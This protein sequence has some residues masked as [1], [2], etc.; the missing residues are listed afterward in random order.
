VYLL[1]TIIVIILIITSL[2]IKQRENEQTL[3][4]QSRKIAAQSLE[5]K[6]NNQALSLILALEAYKHAPTF[7]AQRAIMQSV[8]IVDSRT[9]VIIRNQGFSMAFSPDGQALAIGGLDGKIYLFDPHTLKFIGL[10]INSSQNIIK[11]IAYSSDGKLLATLD[12]DGKIFIWDTIVAKALETPDEEPS[13]KIIGFS[14]VPSYNWLILA[15][16]IEDNGNSE[17]IMWD[18]L[19]SNYIGE[20]F[21]FNCT[22][23][24][25]IAT[26]INENRQIMTAY[27]GQLIYFDEGLLEFLGDPEKLSVPSGIE[28]TPKGDHIIYGRNNE[29]AFRTG[30]V[31]LG[32]VSLSN[33]KLNDTTEIFGTWA[34]RIN[35]LA[36]SKDGTT[37]VIGGGGND[38][39]QF[40]SVLK[41]FHSDSSVDYSLGGFSSEVLNVSI[42]PDNI[43]VAAGDLDGNIIL[44]DLTQ[45]SWKNIILEWESMDD[46]DYDMVTF[47]SDSNYVIATRFDRIYTWDLSTGLK[48]SNISPSQMFDDNLENPREVTSPD[49]A[50]KATAGESTL[51]IDNS[52][53]QEL[54]SLSRAGYVKF[55]PNGKYLI[56]YG[57]PS[58]AYIPHSPSVWN[59]NIDDWVKKICEIVVG[60]VSP[61]EW[62]NYIGNETYQLTC[63]IN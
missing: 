34:R 41:N 30:E 11:E 18:I 25:K 44:W 22:R 19:K 20:S 51:L 31:W 42:S 10:P 29:S 54:I 8:Q 37:L 46:E 57:F 55:S 23:C 13:K 26:N 1:G 9:R 36:I 61:E 33:V 60:N 38:G 56:T 52:T 3:I 16:E 2:V 50:L 7:E 27:A 58:R 62:K 47:S 15:R 48:S 35:D 43:L 14:F 28:I 6:D 39:Y 5:F 63:P 21:E 17:I 32:T 53:G 4:A 12:V 45:K 59:V 49:G 24:E 40:V